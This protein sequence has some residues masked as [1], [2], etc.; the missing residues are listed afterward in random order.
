[1]R[2]MRDPVNSTFRDL[3]SRLVFPSHPSVL[4]LGLIAAVLAIG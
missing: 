4:G 3:I 1:V 2:R